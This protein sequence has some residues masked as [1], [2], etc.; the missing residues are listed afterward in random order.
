MSFPTVF[1]L[2]ATAAALAVPLLSGSVRA[3]TSATYPP[4]VLPGT[5]DRVLAMMPGRPCC[6]LLISV[7]EGKAPA[8]GW[9]VIYI[10]DGNSVFGTLRDEVRRESADTYEAP[11]VIVAIGYP[12]DDPWN[13]AQRQHDLT[14]ALPSGRA[15]IGPAGY[16]IPDTGGAER[17]LDYIANV[18]KPSIT[19]DF[20][21]DP[22]RQT[23]A[24][25]SLGG[26]FTLYTA[27]TR[28]D[29]FQ[30]YA[31]MSPSIWYGD[32]YILDIEDKTRALRAG[33]PVHARLLLTIGGCEQTPGEC[34]PGVPGSVQKNDW[35]QWQGRMVDDV[36]QMA[37]RLNGARTGID[38]QAV[39]FAGE[40]HES[41]LGTS[42]AR[43]VRF[44][45]SPAEQRPVAGERKP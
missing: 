12:G 4:V 33:R 45:L 30:T 14:P 38:A 44:A 40:H 3:E 16:A 19:R 24:G 6:R 1:R 15:P 9:P 27:F 42:I 34:D 35:L 10:L 36:R 43:L 20:P 31:A 11:A 21:V 39:V 8:A 26:L 17:F 28:P 18:V 32:R 29:L 5:Q 2:A 25:H 23:L 22:H 13:D 37:D 41:V 7:P